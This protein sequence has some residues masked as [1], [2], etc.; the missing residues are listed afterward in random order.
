MKTLKLSTLA[1]ALGSLSFG[2]AAEGISDDVIRI[3]FVTDMSGVYS[4]YDGKNGVEAIKLAIEDFGGEINGKKIELLTAD[5]Q[6]KADIASARAR[7]W[8]D[9]E[10][11]DV[12]IGGTNSAASLAMSSVANDK[13]KL[14]ISAG[15]GASGLINE[16]CNPYTIMWT[17][18][19]SAIAKGTGA[20]VVEDGGD[21][22]FFIT[23]DYT[24]GH[25]LEQETGKIVEEAGG[26]VVGSVRTPLGAS[27]FSSFI[28]QAQ[29]S[30]AKV[31]GL[32]NAGG[33]FINS[34][35]AAN[36]F[37]LGQTMSIVGMTVFPQDVHNLGL[38]TT[39][40][41]YFTVPWDWQLSPEAEE[42]AA[43]MEE[44]IQQKPSY[45]H[46]GDYSAVSSYLKAVSETG[47]DDSDTV[48]EWLKSATIDDVFVKG[49][50]IRADGRMMNDMYLLQV[51]TPEESTGEWDYV[52]EVARIPAAEVHG[53]LEEGSCEFAKEQQS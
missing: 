1:L 41:M 4:D 30:G 51:K 13:K 36:D 17:Y 28:L 24:Y 22:W 33:D 11:L 18:S 3:G 43:R 29:N 23:T 52:K 8:F 39:Q 42:F 34:I 37:G 53:T 14:F 45:I 35:K 9:S 48:M 2:V 40:G 47:T 50:K 6:N 25:M 7:E 21:S 15:A 38:E 49:G 27:D 5:H 16:H 12:L 32:A 31:V 19:T 20:A 10:K 44:K 46:A 26:E